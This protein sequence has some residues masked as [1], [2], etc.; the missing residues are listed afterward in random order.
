[1]DSLGFHV[2]S[3]IP[4]L[5]IFKRA[6]IG[7]AMGWGRRMG[8]LPPPNMVLS[9]SIPTPPRII[10]KTFAPHPRPLGPH[11]VPPHPIK[12]YFFVNLP[13]N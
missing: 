12:L 10:G 11:E 7:M 13:Y 9:C 6:R 8:S 5:S 3:S 1:M 4:G 2:M